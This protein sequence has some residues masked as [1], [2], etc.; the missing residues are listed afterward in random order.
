M[1]S[2]GILLAVTEA[3]GGIPCTNRKRSCHARYSESNS[4]RLFRSD[5]LLLAAARAFVQLSLVLPLLS[6]LSPLC[7]PAGT[8][9]QCRKKT[10]RQMLIK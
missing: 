3:E 7:A 8:E 9:I 6:I 2:R 1:H 10:A 4:R 5:E